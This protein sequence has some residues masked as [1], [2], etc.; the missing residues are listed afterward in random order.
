MTN[1]DC[2]QEYLPAEW[3][4]ALAGL[5]PATAERVQELRLRADRP[6]G[7]SLTEGERFLTPHGMTA[8]RQRDVYLCT[9]A[10]L[11][12]CFLRFCQDAVYAHEW[13]LS[14]GYVAVPGGIRV[15]VA[16]QAVTREGRICSV[17]RV[18]ALC[19][20]LPRLVRGCSDAL[21]RRITASATPISTLLV[22]A[23]SS[24]KTTLLRDLASGWAAEGMRVSVVDERGELS[25]GGG[26]EGCDVLLGYPKAEGVRQAVRCL[27]P[28]VIL[29]DELGGET[30]AAAVS[31]CAH[32]GVAVVATLHGHRPDDLWRQPLSRLLLQ[33]NSFT[34]WAFLTGRQRPGEV[35]GVYRPE[36][37]EDGVRWLRIDSVGGERSGAVCFP[38]SASAGDRFGEDRAAVTAV[39]TGAGL[40]RPPDER[41][42]AVAG[43]VG[44]V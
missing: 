21:R 31:A 41:A 32:A 30:E 19:V 4:T 20:R 44:V 17:Q 29:F 23:P 5:P 15:G 39:D 3:L 12:R 13:E 18:T 1:W 26:L 10:Q 42:V 35:G 40:Y 14:Q 38:P 28:D 36:V 37:A 34:Y 16:G 27:A 22:G 6:V 7:V 43:G 11:E 24:G 9:A 33:R 2:L 8:A 25:G